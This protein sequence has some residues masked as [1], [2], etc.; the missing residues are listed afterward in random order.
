MDQT[1]NNL[2]KNQNIFLRDV[3]PSIK[4]TWSK[5]ELK[6]QEAQILRQN[7]LTY[8]NPKIIQ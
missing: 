3:T 8:P 1:I 4:V 2:W 7:Y 6:I 5:M